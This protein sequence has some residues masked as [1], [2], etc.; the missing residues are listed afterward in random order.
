MRKL[1]DRRL[2]YDCAG[3]EFFTIQDFGGL[4]DDWE[5]LGEDWVTSDIGESDSFVGIE[6]K[7]PLEEVL[8]LFCTVRFDFLLGLLDCFRVAEGGCKFFELDFFLLWGPM[9]VKLE[10]ELHV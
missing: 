8:D 10:W 4:G 7:Y 5:V 6:F 1:V 9:R 2:F 3:L